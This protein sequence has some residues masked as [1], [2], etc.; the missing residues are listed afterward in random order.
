MK[1]FK[2]KVMLLML[3]AFTFVFSNISF[4]AEKPEVKA[5]AAILIEP[6]TGKVLFEKN[7]DK[8]MYPAS[9]TKLLTAIIALD[10]FSPDDVILVGNEINEV[11]LDSSK[12]GHVRGESITVRNLI[13]GLIIPSGNDTA[14]VIAN[15]V[16][17]KVQN[18]DTLSPKE[19]DVLFSEMMNKKAEELGCT[20][21]N[22]SNPHGYHDE[23][24]Y[25]NAHDMSKIASKAL[26]Y[27]VLMQ[28]CS[29]KSYSGNSMEDKDSAG[30]RTKEYNW[31]S[32]NL[33]ITNGEYAYPYATGLKTGFTDEAGDCIA[34]SAEKDGI[35]LVAIIFNSEDPGRWED[36]A[37]L[38]NYGF[39]N[40]NFFT[41]A[42]NGSVV[43][44]VPLHN[45]NK[46][47]G[48][49]LD[50]IIKEDISLYLDK[51]VLGAIETDI[52]ITNEEYIY[53]EDT[54]DSET[55]TTFINAPITQD[56]EIGK[57][58]YKYNGEVLAETPVYAGR[59]VEEATFFEKIG[60]TFK[61]IASKLF[62]KDGLIKFGIGAAVII[63][64]A[65][66]IKFVSS[67]RRRS[68]NVYKFKNNKRRRY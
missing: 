6:S 49:N 19:C 10:N 42:Q 15:A 46:A 38:F 53:Q 57:V 32:H 43:G 20:N 18:D 4:A 31:S 1:I 3:L 8:K 58:S 17:K 30:V 21:T 23:N 35:Q 44:Q 37:A 29:E 68:R 11:S 9:M 16:V 27:D 67:R 60:Y 7:A 59:T 25:T 24:H 62:T 36:A 48:D 45:H 65:L 52:E 55:P 47:D 54:K 22:F 61:D 14:E 66:I 33:L 34:A 51:E 12:A 2:Q 26:E 13:R 50:L 41:I 5:E 28:I 56:T 40:Y 39:E 64:I 63:V